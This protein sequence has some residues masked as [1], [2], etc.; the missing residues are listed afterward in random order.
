MWLFMWLL[1]G[2]KVSAQLV[3][4]NQ[5]LFHPVIPILRQQQQQFSSYTFSWRLVKIRTRFSPS[6]SSRLWR[7]TLWTSRMRCFHPQIK[8][9]HLPMSTMRLSKERRVPLRLRKQTQ[10]TQRRGNHLLCRRPITKHLVNWKVHNLEADKWLGNN[11]LW[12]KWEN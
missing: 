7:A 9:M 8:W 4:L 12:N 2:F 5:S 3:S 6:T 11:Y 1:A 10:S